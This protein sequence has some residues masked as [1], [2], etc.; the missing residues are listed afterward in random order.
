MCNFAA[1]SRIS[2]R[3]LRHMVSAEWNL[4]GHVL[5]DC[6][7]ITRSTGHFSCEPNASALRAEDRT[8]RFMR[9]H[10]LLVLQTF[11]QGS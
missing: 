11:L 6:M 1:Q 2:C 7:L 10:G 5:V 9:M 4:A 8:V 3:Y